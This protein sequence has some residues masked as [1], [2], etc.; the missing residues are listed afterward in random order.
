MNL[1][2]RAITI[3]V[4]NHQGQTDKS[5]NPYILHP[6][7]LMLQ[8]TTEEEMITAVLHDVIE[9]TSISLSALAQQKFPDSILNALS[10]LTHTDDVSYEDYIIAIKTNPLAC[11]VKLADLRHN[12]DVLRL[13]IIR[14]KDFNRLQKYRRAWEVLTSA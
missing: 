14:D 9:D 4:E 5:G 12:M 3:A 11:A 13:P 2:E 8:M 1:L 7:H 10:L 6:L